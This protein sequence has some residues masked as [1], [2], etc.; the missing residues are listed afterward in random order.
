MS[1]LW[2]VGG[3]AFLGGL[4][5]SAFMFSGVWISSFKG[6]SIIVSKHGGVVL[7]DDG[8][9]KVTLTG[10]EMEVKLPD[11]RVVKSDELEFKGGDNHTLTLT[12]NSGVIHTV[13]SS[14]GHIEVKGDVG[15]DVTTSNGSVR[16]G[17]TVRGAVRTSNGSIY[18]S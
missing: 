2:L 10:K 17:G 1:K 6:K 12:V 16:V 18:H 14:N 11:G 5:A 3:V 7:S 4:A 9:D 15:G 8:D 13:Q